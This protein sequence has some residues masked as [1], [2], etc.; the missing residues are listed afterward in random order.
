MTIRNIQQIKWTPYFDN[1]PKEQ[2]HQFKKFIKN[3]PLK[4]ID[5]AGHKITYIDCG[6]GSKTVIFCHGALVRSDMFF[7]S[8]TE[9]EKKY[10]IIAPTFTS[11]DTFEAVEWIKIIREKEHVSTFYIIGYSFGGGIAQLLMHFHPDWL[12]GVVLTHTSN[13]YRLIPAKKMKVISILLHFLPFSFIIKK[14]R[15]RRKNISKKLKWYQFYQAYFEEVTH[16]LKKRNIIQWI[17]NT[18][19][20]IP[21]IKRISAPKF[22]KPIIILGTEGDSDAF[23]YFHQLCEIYPHAKSHIFIEEGGHHYLFLHPEKYTKVLNSMVSEMK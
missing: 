12:D 3:H 17:N 4:Q 15:R 11:M 22:R 23:P 2:L 5:N 19:K 7:H 14:I 6:Q 21:K 9:M 18:N 8:I 13:I 1:V 10:R 20:L 16:S